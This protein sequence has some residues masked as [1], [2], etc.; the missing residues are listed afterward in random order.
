MPLDAPGIE[1]DRAVGGD[2]AE[3]VRD[4]ERVLEI[5]RRD[6][7][8]VREAR[9]PVHP[10][11]VHEDAAGDHRRILLEPALVPDA[12]AE[13]L[14]RRPPVP[15]QAVVSEVVERVDPH[16]GLLHRG[17]EK[18][19]EAKTYL[20]AIPYFDR[21]DYVAPMNQEHAFALAVEKLCG[22]SVPPRA[23]NAL[24]C[25]CWAWA[26]L[27][28]SVACSTLVWAERATTAQVAHRAEPMAS[29]PTPAKKWMEYRTKTEPQGERMGASLAA[30]HGPDQ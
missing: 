12:A 19:I 5:L 6:R 29:N 1:V 4:R 16:I 17:T 21:L 27:P 15:E 2:R 30:K 25:Q 10:G 26:K 11:N 22:I 24:A 28:A 13:I 18:L 23:C 14:V 9:D 3:R 8:A 7:I 20:Q